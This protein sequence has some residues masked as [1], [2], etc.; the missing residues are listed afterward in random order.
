MPTCR[1]IK[2]N[3][4]YHLAQKPT[5]K[6][7]ILVQLVSRLLRGESLTYSSMDYLEEKNSLYVSLRLK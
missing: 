6:F 5:P 4:I 3:Q 1:R 2:L 7:E